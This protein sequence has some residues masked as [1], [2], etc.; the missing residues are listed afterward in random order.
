MET[1]NK[2]WW[3]SLRHEVY[4]TVPLQELKIAYPFKS[5]LRA[6]F[7]FRVSDAKR[8]FLWIHFRWILPPDRNR[9]LAKY[10]DYANN[11]ARPR[12]RSW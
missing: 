11:P 12:G 4:I 7:H 2:S 6:Q 5:F 3:L 1:L 8:G 10:R 9:H